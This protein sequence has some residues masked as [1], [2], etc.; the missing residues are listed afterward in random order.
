MAVRSQ[1]RRQEAPSS[2]EDAAR[3]LHAC[4]EEGLSTRTIGAGTK[5]DWGNVVTEPDVEISTAS[6]DRIVE[7][8]AGD[9]TAVLQ[10][11]VP[12]RVARDQFAEAGQMLA[13]DPPLGARAGATIGGV[14]AAGD[15]GP[16]RHR[17]GAARDLVL[18]VTVALP[19]GTVARAGGKVIKN[20]AGYDLAKLFAG[21]FGTLGTIVEVAVRLHPLRETVSVAAMGD[22]ADVVAG[23][24][25]RL[26]HAQHE[27]HALDI[28]WRDGHGGVLARFAGRRAGTEA[29]DA[30]ELLTAAGLEA[31]IV[32]DDAK[33]W[34]QQRASQRGDLIVR[35]SGVQT[36]LA[37]VLRA[38][39]AAGGSV[40]GRAALGLYWVKLPKAG[41]APAVRDLRSAVAPAVAVVLDAPPLLKAEIDPWA[42]DEGPELE[43]MR[44]TKARFDPAGTCSAGIYAGGI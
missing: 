2:Y 14:V 17:Y 38:A 15:S 33:A 3:L 23:A 44:R 34:E 29:R 10:A 13:L 16:L 39:D 21:S 7:H 11:G 22:N 4:A 19:D 26:A 9:L 12:L 31:T 30:S 41:G 20:V 1:A 37:D 5:R 35:V 43:L 32:H 6:L 24:A 36:Q 25:Q 27:A 18:G 42:V 40:V 28:A 8:N